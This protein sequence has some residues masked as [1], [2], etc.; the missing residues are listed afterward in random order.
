MAT[1][2]VCG[3]VTA[4]LTEDGPYRKKVKNDKSLR[5]VLKEFTI[6]VGVTGPDNATGLGF[7]SYL[8]ND[9]YKNLV[10]KTSYWKKKYFR[11]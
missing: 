4:L 8:T 3:F 2:H 7:L 9:E 6:D 5:E 10:K 1:P 11:P